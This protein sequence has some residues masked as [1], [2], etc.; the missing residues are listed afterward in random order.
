[1]LDILTVK[2]GEIIIKDTPLIQIAEILK[3]NSSSFEVLRC[4]FYLEALKYAPS[5][6]GILAER[7]FA[8]ELCLNA[9]DILPVYQGDPDVLKAIYSFHLV[10]TYYKMAE[11]HQI[12]IYRVIAQAIGLPL[13]HSSNPF[14]YFEFVIKSL[15]NNLN[16]YDQYIV[17]YKIICQSK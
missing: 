2:S 11:I 3:Q 10:V 8:I 7:L 17:F 13:Q 6:F 1:M 9:T 12:D 4:E 16:S 14:E 5:T 15:I